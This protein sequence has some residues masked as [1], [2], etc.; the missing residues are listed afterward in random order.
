MQKQTVLARSNDFFR[1]V[2]IVDIWIFTLVGMLC[3]WIGSRT[4][5]EYG[6]TL[7]VAALGA[8]AIG[9]IGVIKSTEMKRARECHS[10]VSLNRH[11]A[12]V[13]SLDEMIESR[14]SFQFFWLMTAVASVAFIAGAIMQFG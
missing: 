12:R 6:R 2:M 10:A 7:L 1:S 11:G 9:V 5:G 8:V 13:R 14:D 3:Y 4:V